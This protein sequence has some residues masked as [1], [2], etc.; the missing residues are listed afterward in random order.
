M[1]LEGKVI[2]HYVCT[3]CLVLVFKILCLIKTFWSHF[4]KVCVMKRGHVKIISLMQ[5]FVLMR[6]KQDKRQPLLE[7]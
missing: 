5:E 7:V 6:E 3:M 4:Q 2:I 1:L